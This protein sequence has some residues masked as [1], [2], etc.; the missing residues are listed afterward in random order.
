MD[1]AELGAW[2]R[3]LMA[4]GVGPLAARK[5]LMALGSPQAVASAS[6]AAIRAVLPRLDPAKLTQA[7]EGWAEQLERS[8]AWLHPAAA[9]PPASPEVPAPTRAVITLADPVYPTTL[10]EAA[11]PPLLL[12]AEGDL[13]LL[14]APSV[15]VV[16]SRNPTAQGAD[17]AHAFAQALSD[18]GVTVVSGLARGVDAAAH[19]GALVSCERP[20]AAGQPIGGRTVAVL[21]T[22]LQHIYPRSNTK[23]A[24]RIAR[25]GLLV[26]EFLLDTPPLPSNFPK[27]NRI[28]AALSR[29]TLVVEAAVQSGSLI[30]ARLASELGREVLAIPGSIHSPQARGCHALIKQG[31]KLVETAQDVL[32]E[33]RLGG[34]RPGSRVAIGAAEPSEPSES[35]EAADAADVD[36]I[37]R[38]MG[39]DPVS[40][41]ALS[42][43]TGMGPGELGARLLELELMG[44]VA[45]LPG[46][47]FQRLGRA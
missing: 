23:L 42:A 20:A 16:G 47:L 40:Q 18:A 33:L 30:T 17:N 10:L 8:W 19:E 24:Q 22:G 26:S 11:D 37:L 5:L 1:R 43:R 21:G 15:A 34:A 45:R 39:H 35:D 46:Q 31:A 25:H 6:P 28:V 3:L 32:E 27:R 36:P 4:P 41:E 2:L 12:F 38:A 14:R 44:Q 9:E 7:P 13:S 29:G